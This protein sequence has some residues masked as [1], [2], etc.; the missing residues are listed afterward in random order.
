MQRTLLRIALLCAERGHTVEIFTGTWEGEK[1]KTLTVHE[2]DLHSTTNHGRNDEL[3]LRVKD[4][5]SNQKFDCIVGFTK[6]PGL[7]I[8]YAGDPCFLARFTES[9][10]WYYR[11]LPRYRRFIAQERDVFQ[12]GLSTEI[13]LIAHQERENFIKYYQTEA[14]RFS[15]L[16]PGINR[17]L[18]I[19][20]EPSGDARKAIREQFDVDDDRFL[21]LMVGSGFRTKGVDRAIYALAALPDGLRNNVHLVVVGEGKANQFQRLAH[22]VGVGENVEFTGAQP[23]AARYY[24]SADL[25]IHPAYTE[26]TGTTLIEAMVC[27]L[28]VLTTANCGFSGHVMTA[29]A[30]I[31]CPSPYSQSELNRSLHA[32]LTSPKDTIELWRANG[33][34]YCRKVDLYSLID[35][36]A[37]RIIT[38]AG[39]GQRA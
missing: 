26:N 7:D 18:L 28:P 3:A 35:K 2:L 16:P 5:I 20:H 12:A 24:Y 17:E 30:G 37:D 1:P 14:D 21:V 22:N 10:P 13:L 25:L 9:K 6:M 11:F 27:G 19:E 38:R 36:A 4:E 32:M 39:K 33:P 29:D 15:L 23:D 8:Y 34:E 31:V